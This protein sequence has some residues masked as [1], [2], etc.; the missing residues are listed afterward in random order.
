MMSPSAHLGVKSCKDIDT[1]IYD[2]PEGSCA[3]QG[4]SVEC[5]ACKYDLQYFVKA[6]PAEPG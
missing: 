4:F 6:R 5:R 2:D 1:D 3:E